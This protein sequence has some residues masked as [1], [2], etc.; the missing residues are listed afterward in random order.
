MGGDAEWL[1]PKKLGKR[2]TS[3]WPHLASVVKAERHMVGGKMTYS[4]SSRKTAT[5]PSDGWEGIASVGQSVTTLAET[6]AEADEE[7]ILL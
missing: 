7:P 6:G 5:P 2:L 1:T 4:L 3:L